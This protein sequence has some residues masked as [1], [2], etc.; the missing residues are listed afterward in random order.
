MTVGIGRVLDLKV[1]AVAAALSALLTEVAVHT[2]VQLH[3]FVLPVH[4]SAHSLVI[5]HTITI[6]V[7]SIAH[8]AELLVA[9]KAVEVQ[10]SVVTVL[11]TVGSIQM[12]EDPPFSVL[13]DSKVQYCLLLS[14]VNAGN[15]GT[16]A[17]LVVGLYL[18]H[19]L[20]RQVLQY[21]VSVVA[22]KL[23]T[24][25]Q[26]L[27][28]ILSVEGVAAVLVLYNTRQFLYQFLYHGTVLQFEGIRIVHHGI[29]H[30]SQ[31]W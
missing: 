2:T 6:R 12:S 10:S 13:L 15:T 28:D 9:N 7:V 24:V 21:H 23:L 5:C 30:H 1:L 14:V 22:E 18:I 19:Y 20:C 25:H 3:H 29:I 26:N 27:A 31:F 16:V 8:D 4:G 11:C 17:L